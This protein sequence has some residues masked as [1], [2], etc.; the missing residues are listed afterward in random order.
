MMPLDSST[1]SIKLWMAWGISILEMMGA[2]LPN[3]FMWPRRSFT[4]PADLCQNTTR[5]RRTI[6]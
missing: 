5:Q 2:F 1:I 6:L 4:S 3:R